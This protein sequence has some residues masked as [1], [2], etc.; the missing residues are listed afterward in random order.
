MD[1]FPVCSI[2]LIVISAIGKQ[3]RGET[4][5]KKERKDEKEERGQH[6]FILYYSGP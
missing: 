6:S 2:V 3:K 1:V 5:I 4:E